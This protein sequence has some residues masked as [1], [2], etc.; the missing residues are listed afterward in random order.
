M[1]IERSSLVRCDGCGEVLSNLDQGA[2]YA[3]DARAEA[4]ANDPRALLSLPG[5]RDLC[6]GCADDR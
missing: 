2:E 6:S 5:G 4:R 3:A 1:S